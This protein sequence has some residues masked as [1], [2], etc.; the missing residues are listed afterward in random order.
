LELTKSFFDIWFSSKTSS[1][2][3]RK[4]LLKDPS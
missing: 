4:E 3:L 2:E 1:P